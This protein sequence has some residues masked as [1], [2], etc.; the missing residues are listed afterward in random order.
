[1]ELVEV[2]L[3]WEFTRAEHAAF[4]DTAPAPRRAARPHKNSFVEVAFDTQSNV[5]F[6]SI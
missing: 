3:W 6:A 5:N 4:G 1:M 2:V